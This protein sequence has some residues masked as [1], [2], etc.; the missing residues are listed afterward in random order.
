MAR[1][2]ET[3]LVALTTFAMN[4]GTVVH[5]GQT[6]RVGH[7]LL[8]GCESL[9]MPIVVD[10]EVDEQPSNSGRHAAGARAKANPPKSVV[11]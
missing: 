6:V 8:K 5:R 3:I 9:F 4:D 11:N 7:P 2:D 1:T 10:F